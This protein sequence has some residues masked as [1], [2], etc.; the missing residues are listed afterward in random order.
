MQTTR[1]S[2]SYGLD[3]LTARLGEAGSDWFLLGSIS[4]D[5]ELRLHA[6]EQSL[7]RS[8]G[9]TLLY[10]APEHEEKRREASP[11]GDNDSG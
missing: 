5:G 7:P 6:D 9:W 4:P 10:F 1:L 2:E 3:E 8:R 11:E